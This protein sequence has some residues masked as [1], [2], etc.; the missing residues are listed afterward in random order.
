MTAP[1]LSG[2]V[3]PVSPLFGNRAPNHVSPRSSYRG[4]DKHLA[5]DR[6]PNSGR[7]STLEPQYPNLIVGS[8]LE[9]LPQGVAVVTRNL[10]LIYWNSK[11]RKICHALDSN[12]SNTDLPSAVT[13]VCYRLLRHASL[14]STSL[15]M[16][17]SPTS[18]LT[19]RIHG[20]WLLDNF[21]LD[22]GAASTAQLNMVEPGTQT[23]E[24]PAY[25]LILLE[26]CHDTLQTELR[27]DQK[28]YDLTDREAEIWMLLRQD[29]SYQEIAKML[30]ISLNTVK[31][32]VKNAYAKKRSCQE[33]K[34][35]WFCE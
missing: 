1:L 3:E 9:A 30:R 16:E 15:V 13:E 35:F 23:S 31:T 4:T 10:K 2:S 26:N 7:F 28:K 27:I 17:Y 12:S 24:K 20:R 25:M 5:N 34:R 32:H 18:E 22:P 19:V 11:A 21:N 8:L 33:Q 14:E 29:Y 6:N